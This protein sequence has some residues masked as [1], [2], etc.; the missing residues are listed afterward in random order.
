VG[1]RNLRGLLPSTR[2]P[3]GTYLWWIGCGASRIAE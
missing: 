2:G 3:E 1:V